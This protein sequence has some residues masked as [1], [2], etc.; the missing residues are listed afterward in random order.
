[1]KKSNLLQT[2]LMKF[3]YPYN[4]KY[5]QNLWFDDCFKELVGSY[6]DT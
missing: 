6:T 3:S 2:Y 4:E 5:I 1:M